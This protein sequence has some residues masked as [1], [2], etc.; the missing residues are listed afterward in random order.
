MVFPG[1]LIDTEKDSLLINLGKVFNKDPSVAFQ[2][3]PLN[4]KGAGKKIPPPEHGP[5][6][7]DRLL[8]KMSGV[9]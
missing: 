6:G 5:V 9:I 8:G 4:M 7:E 2:N 1:V 3:F